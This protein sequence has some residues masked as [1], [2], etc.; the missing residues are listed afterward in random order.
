MNI[1]NAVILA[2]GLSS[3]LLPLSLACPKALLPVK[4]EV[5]IERQ[6][7]QLLEAGISEVYVVTGYM[8]EHFDYLKEK[9]PVRLVY[10]PEYQRRNNHSSIYAVREFLGNSYI[11]SGDNYFPRNPFT[12]TAPAPFYSSLYAKGPT[13]EWCLTL[14]KDR[15]ITHVEIGG[16]NAWYMLGHVCWDETFTKTFLSILEKEYNLPRTSP[17]LWEQIYMEH[18][19]RLLLY[20][21]PYQP[22]EILEFDTLADLQAYDPFYAEKS[23]KELLEFFQKQLPL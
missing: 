15:R 8:A 19:D 20:S 10:N 1:E 13:S 6:I 18:L 17:L 21:K 16:A 22:G 5:L 11:C 3:R 7:R 2:A 12:A 23:E 4:G 9:F 14:D